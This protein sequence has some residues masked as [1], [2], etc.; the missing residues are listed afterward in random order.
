MKVRELFSDPSKWT[1]GASGRD[2]TGSFVLDKDLDKA[3][4][5]CLYGAIA[6][7]YGI[8]GDNAEYYK[9]RSRVLSHL[10]TDTL[11]EWN[12]ATGRTFEEVKELVDSLD[13]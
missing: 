5:W 1:Q 12:D 10:H 6:R 7:C 9:I 11:S 2:S 4:C 8:E 3:V 13:I